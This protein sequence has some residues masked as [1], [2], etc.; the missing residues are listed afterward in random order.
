MADKSEIVLIGPFGA[1]KST[2]GELVAERLGL[3]SVSLDVHQ[4]YY[5]ELGFDKD[6]FMSLNSGANPRDADLYFAGF[7]PGAVERLLAE[8]HNCVF[9]LGAG[10]TVYS[11][12]TL[13]AQVQRALAS[14]PNVVLV[15]PSPDREESIRVL[16][17]RERERQ[18]N[19][20]FLSEEFDWFGYWVNSHCNYDLAKI[21]IYTEGK[22]SE[23]SAEEL[24]RAA[25]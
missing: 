6:V 4:Y 24:L 13:F 19:P 1:G 10:H 22:T 5:R 8:H 11:D 12:E 20:R 25:G 9:D 21:T 17:E 2:I 14:Y 3:H 23:Q 16:R 18:A 15:T 7:F